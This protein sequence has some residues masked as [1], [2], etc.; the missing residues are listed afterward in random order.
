M[1]PDPAGQAAGAR[2]FVIHV[3]PKDR[4]GRALRDAGA[5][6]AEA[7]GLTAAIHLDVVEQQVAPLARPVM[8]PVRTAVRSTRHLR[9]RQFTSRSFKR[10]S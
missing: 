6:L 10:A 8:S 1:G 3:E 7:V 5:R 4:A 2:A 9:R